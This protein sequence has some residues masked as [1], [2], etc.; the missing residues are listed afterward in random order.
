[1]TSCA[2]LNQTHTESRKGCSSLQKRLRCSDVYTQRSAL[3][4]TA[5]TVVTVFT[6]AAG[7]FPFA[8]SDSVSH[9]CGRCYSLLQQRRWSSL[10]SARSLCG[11]RYADSRLKRGSLVCW[12]SDAPDI[13]HPGFDK[14]YAR[15]RNVLR[16]KKSVWR[17]LRPRTAAL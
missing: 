3:F 5:I 16:K 1:Y 4:V 8:S 9:S 2:H 15:P 17:L 13:S 12:H 10:S 6:G 14:G 11:R 7:T